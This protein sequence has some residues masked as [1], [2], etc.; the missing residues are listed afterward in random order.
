MSRIKVF[1]TTG[2][3]VIVIAIATATTTATFPNVV[4][5]ATPFTLAGPP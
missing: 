5:F 1:I 2:I 4:V 3:T